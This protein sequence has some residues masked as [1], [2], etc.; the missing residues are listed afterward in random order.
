[1]QGAYCCVFVINSLRCKDGAAAVQEIDAAFTPAKGKLSRLMLYKLDPAHQ[2]RPPNIPEAQW[3]FALRKAGG[4]KNADGLWPVAVQGL[5]MLKVHRDKQLES[6]HANREYLGQLR[7]RVQH[8]ADVEYHELRQRTARILRRHAELA[9]RLLKVRW[10]FG[11]L[12][13][14]LGVFGTVQRTALQGTRRATL[15]FL[16]LM[17]SAAAR[18]ARAPPPRSVLAV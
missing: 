6:A 10:P 8:S 9:H 3:Q 15:A 2:A 13:C 16:V 12:S 18:R 17:P 14:V 7:S 5:G 11:N 1:M 4:P